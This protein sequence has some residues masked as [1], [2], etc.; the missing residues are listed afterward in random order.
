MLNLTRMYELVLASESPRRR[1][2]LTDAG[3]KFQVHPSKISETLEENLT[4]DEQILD[5]AIRKARASVQT[6]NTTQGPVRL[7]LAADTMVIL[8]QRPLGKPTDPTDAIKTLKS[9]S[10]RDHLVKTSVCLLDEKT[11]IPMSWIE[12]TTVSFRSLSA[13]EIE[14]YVKSGEPLD[15]AGSYGIQGD[16]G[17][18]VAEIRGSYTNVVGLPMESVIHR[19]DV[20]FGLRP[21]RAPLPLPQWIPRSP[22]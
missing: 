11:K 10:G 1:E 6:L 9:L 8:D 22:P 7:V 14:D 13:R 18:F 12:T 15:K 3:F 17:Q 2:L 16:G 20:N 21:T 5:I 4:V 19:L